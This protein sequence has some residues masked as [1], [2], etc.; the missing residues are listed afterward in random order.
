MGD[1]K[2]WRDLT[3]TQRTVIGTAASAQILLAAGA[4]WDLARRPAARVRGP[5]WVWALVIA[6]NFVGPVLYFARGRATSTGQSA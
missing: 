4:W 1:R 5:K 3:A 6:V 2:R